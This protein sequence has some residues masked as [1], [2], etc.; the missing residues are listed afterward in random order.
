MTDVTE[1]GKHFLRRM[2]GVVG[3][4]KSAGI[5]CQTM[6]YYDGMY[7][8]IVMDLS[9][10]LKVW[11]GRKN[12]DFY[13]ERE[14]IDKVQ[15]LI[16]HYLNSHFNYYPENCFAQKLNTDDLNELFKYNLEMIF[17]KY[18]FDSLEY[19][20]DEDTYYYHNTK[21]NIFSK[22]CGNEVWPILKNYFELLGEIISENRETSVFLEEV[23]LIKQDL[24]LKIEMKRES[25]NQINVPIFAVIQ[26]ILI[27]SYECVLQI[28]K[29]FEDEVGKINFLSQLNENDENTDL[30]FESHDYDSIIDDYDSDD[31]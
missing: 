7:D 6:E 20:R 22:I 26:I 19:D 17:T 25:L 18:F 14:E 16:Y 13:F 10:Q 2:I 1:I 21:L 12:G 30:T 23:E 27:G 28:F 4:A 3:N 24:T 8:L 9:L 29:D 15:D 31:D 5:I 11:R